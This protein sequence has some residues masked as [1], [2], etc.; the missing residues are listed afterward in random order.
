MAKI[1]IFSK[2]LE[3]NTFP[4]EAI[5]A[6]FTITGYVWDTYDLLLVFSKQHQANRA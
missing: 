6:I 1:A 2:S 5:S 3:P 4:F